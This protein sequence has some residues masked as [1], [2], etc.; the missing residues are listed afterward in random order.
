[1]EE[2]NECSLLDLPVE[3]VMALIATMTLEDAMS[4]CR[5]HPQIRRVC[6]RNK[7][8]DIKA[9]EYNELQ[10]PLSEIVS[11]HTDHAK[12][13]KRGYKTVYSLD[14]DDKVVFG[15]MRRMANFQM[16]GLPS[17]KGTEVWLLIAFT[18]N[19]PIIDVYA[20]MG[21]M[22]DATARPVQFPNTA[23][24]LL[25]D[26]IHDE[27]SDRIKS[28]DTALWD[29]IYKSTVRKIKEGNFMSLDYSI[30]KVTL[31]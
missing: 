2:E 27:Q 16:V 10:A 21:D 19:K 8:V 14:K 24:D 3:A 17:P 11:T 7:L 30:K 5:T 13:I 1:M 12:L 23:M 6:N 9:R 4:Y 26:Q 29:R 22:L 28:D 20:S 18:N 25:T 15:L 31:P